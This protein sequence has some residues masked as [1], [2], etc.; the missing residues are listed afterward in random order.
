MFAHKT[1]IAPSSSSPPN[2]FFRFGR[3]RSNEKID[4]NLSSYLAS[5]EPVV[6]R[7][8]QLFPQAS[9]SVIGCF[10]V[11]WASCAPVL[12]RK[13]EQKERLFD[14]ITIHQYAPTNKSVE[15]VASTDVERRMV[16]L[17]AVL[18]SLVKMERKV[19]TSISP[20]APIWLDEFNW[21]G[22]WAR[23]PL[24]LQYKRVLEYLSRYGIR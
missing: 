9:V 8:R 11:P 19:A 24:P 10:G 1:H 18:P 21:G 7:A 22:D 4:A 17:G 15:A 3:L 2:V 13:F 6:K 20:N 23:T 5:A 14:A 12:K 16:T